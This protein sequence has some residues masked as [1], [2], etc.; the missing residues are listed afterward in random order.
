LLNK[1]SDKKV[2]L[3]FGSSI[4]WGYDPASG[5]KRYPDDTRWP[6]VMMRELGMDFEVIEEGFSGRTVL[7]HIPHN[8]PANGYQYLNELLERVEFDFIVICLGT[9]DLFANR[10][11]SVKQITEGIERM[12][13]R[14]KFLK[15][16]ANIIIVAPPQINEDFDAA[17]LYQS[18]IEKSKKFYN[19]YKH[20]ASINS[21]FFLDAGKVIKNS[22][23]D[24]IHF[25][26]EE[27]IKFGKHMADFIN[28]IIKN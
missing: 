6:S 27:C 8:H 2:I 4:T 16:K 17:Y 1:S 9:N 12:I 10:E 21:C 14:V 11:I 7:D 26:K 20:I 25:E 3:C 24:G 13:H 19:E 18:E 15:P 5:G 22:K 23:I 28:V